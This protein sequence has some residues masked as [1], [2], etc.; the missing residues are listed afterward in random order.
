MKRLLL[1]FFCAA[2]CHHA[3]ETRPAAD[4]ARTT[5]PAG[6]VSGAPG[7]PPA[8][9]QPSAGA[10]PTAMG[11]AAPATP[12]PAVIDE[13]AMN[14]PVDACSDFYQ[15]AC[16]GWLKAPPRPDDRSV[17]GRGFS[18]IRE[19]NEALLHEMLEKAAK[20]EADPA[21]PFSQKVGDY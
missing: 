18:E 14:K 17:W 15:Y 12:E 6:A 7:A 20:G 8:A 19:R 5:T 21:D 2:A 1:A 3:A 13:T 10:L 11:S 9:G 4:S 16:G